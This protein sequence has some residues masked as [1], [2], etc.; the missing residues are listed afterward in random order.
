MNL[1]VAYDDRVYA[2][3]RIMPQNSMMGNSQFS[4]LAFVPIIFFNEYCEM[5][6]NK[7]CITND[8]YLSERSLKG[9]DMGKNLNTLSQGLL[10]DLLFVVETNAYFRLLAKGLLP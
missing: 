6:G 9:S 2:W 5:Y 3:Y 8:V 10:N 7:R 1:D 4:S